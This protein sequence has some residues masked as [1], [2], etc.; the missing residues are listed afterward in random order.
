MRCKDRRRNKHMRIGYA[1]VSTEEQRVDSQLIYLKAAGCDRIFEDHGFSGV[2]SDR[3][4]L[5]DAL[6]AL[7]PND[8]LVVYKL[9]RLARSLKFLVDLLEELRA[10]GCSFVSLTEGVDTT[11]ATGELL[12]QLLSVIASFERRLISERTRAGMQAAKARG[13]H[14]GRPP[15]QNR[16]HLRY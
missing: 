12:Y 4:G 15:R 16:K 11:T 1:R 8:T 9:D 7:R 5:A 13:V 2:R 14:I 10:R 6:Q 3:P